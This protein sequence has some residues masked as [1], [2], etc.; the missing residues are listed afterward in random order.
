MRVI[1]RKNTKKQYTAAET[2]KGYLVREPKVEAELL[3][4]QGEAYFSLGKIADGKKAYDEAIKIDPTNLLIQADYAFNLARFGKEYEK[5][6]IQIEKVNQIAPNQAPFI[7][8]RG[9]VSFL[10]RR[11]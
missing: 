7:D 11:L 8:T 2:A 5:A 10:Q 6:F 9:M 4:Q 1:K 3:G